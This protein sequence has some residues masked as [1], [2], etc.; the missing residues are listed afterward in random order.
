MGRRREAAEGVCRRAYTDYRA[1]GVEI[2]CD[3]PHLLVGQHAEA[4]E[5]DHEIRARQRLQPG[6]IVA[7]YGIDNAGLPVDGKQHGASEAVPRSEDLRQQR[8]RFLGFVFLIAGDEYDVFTGPGEARLPFEKSPRQ[9]GRSC[10]RV[11]DV[12]KYQ[13][14]HHQCLNQAGEWPV[15]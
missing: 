13:H 8:H 10:A 3:V 6:D 5:H 11:A 7:L 2:G 15:Q 12:E 9:G 4:G 14:S 1:T